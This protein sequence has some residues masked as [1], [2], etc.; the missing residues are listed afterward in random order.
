MG[1]ALQ[2]R[3][4]AVTPDVDKVSARWPQL[5]QRICDAITDDDLPKLPAC[6][7]VLDL[8]RAL[9]Q[10]LR[11]SLS[12]AEPV[13]R[14]V[15]RLEDALGMWQ[16]D[17]ATRAA[18]ELESRLD[19]HEEKLAALQGIVQQPPVDLPVLQL[20]TMAD[21]WNPSLLP[22]LWPTLFTRLFD[23]SGETGQGVAEM[24][25]ALRNLGQRHGWSGE[26]HPAMGRLLDELG[27]R[28]HALETACNM[29]DP[30]TANRLSDQIEELL[31][32]L[33]QAMP[34][35]S[36]ATPQPKRSL[37]AIFG[38]KLRDRSPNCSPLDA[39]SCAARRSRLSPCSIKS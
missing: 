29:N 4:M 11:L 37:W 20:R 39:A 7:S 34:Y 13:V 16:V 15:A 25:Q 31:T 24:V 5:S 21:S 12:E 22:K 23:R 33:E 35:G 27:A 38:R 17:A 36:G 28:W 9:P 1:K 6:R 8:A 26:S 10:T 19:I 14:A 3:L 18:R 32:R 30:R 2:I